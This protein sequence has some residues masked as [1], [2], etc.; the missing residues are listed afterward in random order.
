MGAVMGLRRN[1]T[2]IRVR[3]TRRKISSKV[4]TMLAIAVAI[5]WVLFCLSIT[6]TINFCVMKKNRKKIPGTHVMPSSITSCNPR[7]DYRSSPSPSSPPPPPPPPPPESGAP[8]QHT[9]PQ[10]RVVQKRMN[11]YAA[12]V[13]LNMENDYYSV[14][15]Q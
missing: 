10:A 8:L 13:I 5:T 3:E 2:S 12:S 4:M 1:N 7:N 11:D 15:S 14:Y 9:I 6:L